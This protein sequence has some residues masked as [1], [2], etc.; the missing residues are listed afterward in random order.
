ML[1]ALAALPVR[2][3]TATAMFFL[4]MILLGVFAWF[5]IPIELLPALSGEQLFVSFGRPGSEPEVK[6]TMDIVEHHQVVVLT[7][8]HTNEHAIFFPP[9]D[10]AAGDTPDLNNGYADLAQ[11]LGT[12]TDHGYTNIQQSARDFE[13]AGETIDWSYYATRGLAFT[14]EHSGGPGTGCGRV[15]D[16]FLNCTAA[17]YTGAPI[18]R[19]NS[20]V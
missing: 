2:R 4:A 12:A 15:T 5:R 13:S 20:K 3:P 10:L 18:S 8:G 14:F 6:N 11:A 19:S 17:D 16:N 1:H 9:L 7:T